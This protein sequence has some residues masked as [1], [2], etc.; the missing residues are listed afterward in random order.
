LLGCSPLFFA[1]DVDRVAPVEAF[2]VFGGGYLMN[3]K[4]SSVRRLRGFT[5]IELL[6]V[7]AIIAV[8]IALLLPAVQQ[9]REAARRTQCKNNLKQLGLAIANYESTYTRFPSA[10]KAIDFSQNLL[11]AFPASTFT[12]VLPYLDQGNVYTQFNFAYHYTANVGSPVSSGNPNPIAG[13]TNAV[14]A[15]TNIAAFLCPSNG[16]TQRD[17]LGYGETDYA[18]TAFVDLDPITGLRNKA[19]FKNGGV[20]DAGTTDGSHDGGSGNVNGT[21]LGAT[22]DSALGLYGN[23]IADTTDGLSNTITVFEQAGRPGPSSGQPSLVGNYTTSYLYIGGANG[24]DSTQLPTAG[25]SAQTA[26]SRWADSDSGVGVSGQ[27]NNTAGNIQLLNGN[28]L[29]SG[30]PTSCPWTQNN[31]GANNEPFSTHTGGLHA[32]LGDGTVRFL[33]ENLD[34]HIAV[35]LFGKND[36]NVVGQF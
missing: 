11:Q 19:N 23:R 27:N 35:N 9:A 30:G 4:F 16:Y 6:V 32:L 3:R 18:P 36:G 25:G 29:P 7:I 21:S 24:A 26:P 12:L 33:S 14:A 31:C 1:V 17:T 10:G 8:L 5:L 28:K 15:K 20:N 2:P 13:V 34:W 22:V